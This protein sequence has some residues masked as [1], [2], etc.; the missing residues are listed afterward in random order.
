[1]QNKCFT[2]KQGHALGLFK[3]INKGMSA[4]TNYHLIAA[5]VLFTFIEGC[6]MWLLHL[7]VL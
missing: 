6:E 7:P 3:F 2:V 1:L 4:V 5:F